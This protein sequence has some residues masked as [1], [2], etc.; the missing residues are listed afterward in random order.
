MGS[1]DK[2]YYS[3]CLQ[4]NLPFAIK[5]LLKKKKSDSK[6]VQTLR[7][8]MSARFI[9]QTEKQKISCKDRVVAE[10]IG[11]YRDYYR[12]ALLD[13]KKIDFWDQAL[14]QNLR[15]ILSKIGKKNAISFSQEKIEKLLSVE[16]KKRG[17]YSLF[18]KV[19]PFRSL[20][21]WK[22]QSAKTYTVSLPEKKQK[23]MVVFM[24]EFLELSWLH[25]ATFGRYYVGG[26]AKKNA[27]YCVKQAY[28]VNTPDFMAHY[29]AHE[30]QHF[31]DY[32]SFPKLQQADLEYRAKLAEL[33][34]T[35]HPK[36]FVKKLKSEAKNDPGLPHCFAAY[37]IITKLKVLPTKNSIKEHAAHLLADHSRSLKMHGAKNATSAL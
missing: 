12:K 7:R 20:L 37:Q 16:L 33:F 5:S 15:L 29:L 25:Y 6:K 24:D 8:K 27:L 13:F 26:W 35:A 11:A 21:V 34:L 3:Y 1:P 22:K 36:K 9:T 18:G 28:K 23:A 10:I 30:A 14:I 2:D 19:T 31:A 32:K 17:Y 4:A